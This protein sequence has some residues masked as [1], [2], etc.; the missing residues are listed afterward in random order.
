MPDTALQH[1]IIFILPEPTKKRPT[2]TGSFQKKFENILYTTHL[3]GDKVLFCKYNIE[4]EQTSRI[5]A[6]AE[7][8][9]IDWKKELT[10]L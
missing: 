10:E 3:C 7:I 8:N 5:A 2:Q 6:K 9:G 1:R 4:Q